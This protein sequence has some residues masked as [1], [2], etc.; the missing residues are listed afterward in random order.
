MN[1]KWDGKAIT[2]VSRCQCQAG[3]YMMTIQN[4]F[5]INIK[6]TH[7]EQRDM[8]EMLRGQILLI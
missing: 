6:L 1:Y 2:N 5:G 4:A 3:L 7:G 8:S